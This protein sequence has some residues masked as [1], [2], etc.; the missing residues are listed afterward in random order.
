M[1]PKVTEAR[2]VEGY[3]LWIQFSDGKAG[4]IDLSDELWGPV[5]ESLKDVSAFSKVEVHPELETISWSN[6]ADFA[7]EFLYERIAAQQGATA[8]RKP[9]CGFRVADT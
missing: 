1:I 9:P 6:G 4:V 2:H 3:K 7:P 5:F 8:T